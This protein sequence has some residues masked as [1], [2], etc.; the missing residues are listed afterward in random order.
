MGDFRLTGSMDSFRC[1]LLPFLYTAVISCVAFS[2][3][4]V[5]LYPLNARYVH[6]QVAT[7]NIDK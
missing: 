1:G 5:Y 4:I 3:K 2:E 7:E 6:L